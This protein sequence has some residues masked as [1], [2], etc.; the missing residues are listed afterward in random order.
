MA[1]QITR[2]CHWVSQSYLRA[3]A[4]DDTRQKIWRFS[5]NQ[6]EPELKPIRKVAVRHHLYAPMNGDGKRNDAV[7]KKLSDLERWFGEP[8]WEKVCNDFPDY[9][10]EPLR[11]MVSLLVATTFARNP[12]RFELWKQMHERL[13][14]IASDRDGPPTHITINGI[15][16]EVDLSDWPQFKAAGEEDMK[17]AWNDYVAGAGDIAPTLLKMRWAVLFSEQPVFITSDNPVTIDHPSMQQ[18]GLNDPETVV[19]F[20]L[21]P[22]RILMMDNRHSEPDSQYYPI[23]F[24]PAATNLLTWRNSIE[25][26]FSR[27]HPD[28]VCR[29]M[30]EDAERQGF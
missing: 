15:R 9:S 4:A 20:P 25:H 7:E 6:G 10:W 2:R 5:K 28:E 12:L 14:G 30:V 13:R 19:S 8:I 18:K 23:R 11:K 1:W 27:R 17:A 16:H 29:E 21:S 3:F 26:M 22:T 24:D